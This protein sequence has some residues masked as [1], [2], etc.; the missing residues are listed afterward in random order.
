MNELFY[1]DRYRPRYREGEPWIH[2]LY[3]WDAAL[4]YYA[5]RYDHNHAAREE[6]ARLMHE[7]VRFY[8]GRVP[9]TS[10]R[11]ALR[12][13]QA[14]FSYQRWFYLRYGYYPMFSHVMARWNRINHN[15]FYQQ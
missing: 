11:Q 4:D 3:D 8:K 6:Y 15:H 14:D 13:M 2:R 12:L 5:D 7:I 1:V 9:C 10:W